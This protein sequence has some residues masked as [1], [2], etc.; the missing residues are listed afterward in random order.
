MSKKQIIWGIIGIAACL[1]LS[2]MAPPANLVVAEGLDPQKSMIGMGLLVCALIWMIFR[3]LPEYIVLLLMC[4]YQ[5]SYFCSGIQPVQRH[6]LLAVS[7]RSGIRCS[8]SSQRTVKET[9]FVS[10]E[11]IPGNLSGAVFRYYSFWCCY[12]SID[13]KWYSKTGS[14]RPCYQGDWT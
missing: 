7:W 6:K 13:S 9:D 2:V 1:G 3:V 8:S 5:E 4:S 14:C 10:Y 11:S 12:F